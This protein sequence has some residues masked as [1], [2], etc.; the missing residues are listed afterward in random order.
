MASAAVNKFADLTPEEFKARYT[1]GYRTKEKISKNVA[2]H[3]LHKV[4][5]QSASEAACLDAFALEDKDTS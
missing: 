4:R 3:L 2:L 5:S 1:G